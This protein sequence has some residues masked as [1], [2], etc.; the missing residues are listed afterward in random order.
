MVL[1][2]GGSSNFIGFR[3]ICWGTLIGAGFL[4]ML[5]LVPHLLGD[6][7]E[8]GSRSAHFAAS[9]FY[10]RISRVP[11]GVA[12]SAFLHQLKCRA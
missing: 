5:F 8:I 6:L 2:V 9:L 11:K 4:A 7:L 12:A 10:N 3:D 1:E